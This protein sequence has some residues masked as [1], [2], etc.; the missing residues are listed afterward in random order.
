MLLLTRALSLCHWTCH[1]WHLLYVPRTEKSSHVELHT[2]RY[3]S[4]LM[5]REW[6]P[7]LPLTYFLHDHLRAGGS[8]TPCQGRA[9]SMAALEGNPFPLCAYLP[10]KDMVAFDHPAGTEGDT[11]EIS[12]P[13][14]LPQPLPFTLFPLPLSKPHFFFWADFAIGFVIIHTQKKHFQW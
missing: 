10:A 5:W 12:Q 7:R 8:E 1:L 14:S 2:V 6:P 3:H 4:V 13:L 11:N 9:N